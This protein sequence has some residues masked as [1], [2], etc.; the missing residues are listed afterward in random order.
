MTIV[1]LRSIQIVTS[2]Q[3]QEALIAALHNAGIV[4]LEGSTHGQPSSLIDKKI[5]D[6]TQKIK[7]IAQAIEF[8]KR[9][10]GSPH[11]IPER[12]LDGEALLMR[13]KAI[14][15][16]YAES[17]LAI[18]EGTADLEF[19]RHFGALHIDFQTLRRAGLSLKLG[20]LSTAEYQ[21]LGNDNLYWQ[22]VSKESSF[23]YVAFFLTDDQ[24]KLPYTVKDLPSASLAKMERNLHTERQRL[25]KLDQEASRLS[26]QVRI[27][28]NLSN[29]EN[30]ELI[31]LK[32]LT[33]ATA[34]DGLVGM[35][36]FIEARHLHEFRRTLSPFVAGASISSP[37]ITNVPVLSKNPAGFEGF[38]SL[39]RMY[40]GLSSKESDKTLLTA[41]LFIIFSAFSILDAGY[42]FLLLCVG[43]VMA[44]KKH[45]N[46]GQ[47]SM[48][49]GAA[50]IVLG[51]L[52]G[53]VFGLQW[54]KTIMLT[55]PPVVSVL[56]NPWGLFYVSSLLGIGTMTLSHMCALKQ[57]GFFSSELGSLWALIGCWLLILKQ[58]GLLVGEFSDPSAILLSLA[59][60]SFALAAIMWAIMPL[61][62]L[63]PSKRLP[64]IF[65]TWLS[66][67][68]R[69]FLGVMD[70][71]RLFASALTVSLLAMAVNHI[72]QCLPAYMAGLAATCGHI[73]VFLLSTFL[74]FI[75]S[76]HLIFFEFGSNA[77]Q[78]GHTYF[79][80]FARRNW[81]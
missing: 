51:L 21:T 25:M 43:Y 16:A 40:S 65:W 45:R 42:G 9:F 68:I 79:T 17:R 1:P 24:I 72:A 8:L 69:L 19:Y 44:L 29:A 28:E 78:G 12:I 6:C 10:S 77:I 49:A 47:M 38:S 18:E 31:R 76:N 3:D 2:E 30:L 73:L 34:R 27:L 4:H 81:L 35:S 71:M 37:T 75:H 56:S 64:N 48:W 32:E 7:D 15:K 62:S 46:L 41:I 53:R 20:K 66:E 54:G 50:S 61:S 14:S 22:L 67:P 23:Y 55:T 39:I 11:A 36:G 33:K 74:F 13:T 60:V 26:F 52:A 5:R 59:I 58:S 57:R 80:P 70:H 63:G